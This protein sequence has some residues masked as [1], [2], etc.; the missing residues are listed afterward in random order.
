MNRWRKLLAAAAFAT[1][2]AEGAGNPQAGQQK[3][4]PCQACHGADGNGTTPQFPR[5]AGQYADYMVQALMQYKS[6]ARKNPVMAPFAAP[7]SE[8]DMEDL[9]AYFAEL[10]NGL[11]KKP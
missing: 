11:F 5:L 2:A 10:P 8:R 7:L 3:S 1:A 6:G 4:A 9:A